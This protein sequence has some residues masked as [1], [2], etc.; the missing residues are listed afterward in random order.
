MD[1][2]RSASSYPPQ[3]GGSCGDP[4]FDNCGGSW[5]YRTSCSP[6]Y[7]V[8]C[9]PFNPVTS[10][11]ATVAAETVVHSTAAPPRMTESTVPPGPSQRPPGPS[12]RPPVEGE[13]GYRVA[14]SPRIVAGDQAR[15]LSWPWIAQLERDYFG[16]GGWEHFCG[17]TLISNRWVL[18]AAHCVA[19]YNE[20]EPSMFRVVLGE[21]DRSSTSGHELIMAISRIIVHEDWDPEVSGS[22]SD[23]AL[24]ELSTSVQF[25]DYIQPVC[26]PSYQH[27]EFYP[28]DDCWISGWGDTK[29]TGDNN[30]LQ[31]VKL[32]ITSHE[33]CRQK[34]LTGTGGKDYVKTSHVCVGNGVPGAC[35]G[36]SGGP[37]VCV[38]D[39]QFTLVGATSFG[40]AGCQELDAPNVYT[41]VS[42]FL[43]WILEK[44]SI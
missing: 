23:L 14:S 13:C 40:A 5:D 31:E 32:N 10:T 2:K 11:S 30:V 42:H 9:L 15:P 16:W 33:E 1:I 25:N 4:V 17:S 35:N 3:Q 24:L 8:C 20:A 22:P 19:K 44:I 29:G 41:K 37:L 21:H 27:Q 18:T 43:P 6:S 38:R 34:W 26:L 36:D 7:Q 12:Q 28:T 39:N